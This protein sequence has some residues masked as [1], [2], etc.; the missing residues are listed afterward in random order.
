MDLWNQIFFASLITCPKHCTFHIQSFGIPV[1]DIYLLHPA[2]VN[3]FQPIHMTSLSLE[4]LQVVFAEGQQGSRC[5]LEVAVDIRDFE[6]INLS[7]NWNASRWHGFNL[8]SVTTLVV[9]SLNTV[10]DE[11]DGKYVLHV[12][13]EVLPR[14]RQLVIHPLV[15]SSLQH[16][17]E[18]CG[19]EIPA[20][21]S[22]L[23]TLVFQGMDVTVSSWVGQIWQD[24][25]TFIEQMPSTKVPKLVLR[26]CKTD[27]EGLDMLHTVLLVDIEC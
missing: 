25:R 14:I 24:V 7:P 18:Y 15:L 6:R 16:V 22:A 13:G 17:L 26:D 10:G 1:Y 20:A 11:P 2:V 21:M 3:T 23:E 19:L 4:R 27:Q 8:D 12:L 5:A 9:D